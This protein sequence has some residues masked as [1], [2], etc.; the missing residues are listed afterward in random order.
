MIV[1]NPTAPRAALAAAALA[2]LLVS[3]QTA[4]AG[5]PPGPHVPPIVARSRAVAFTAAAEPVRLALALPLRSR[6]ELDLLLHRLYDPADRLYGQYLSP[7]AFTD[8]F[9][10]TEADY[11]AVADFARAQ[12]LQVVGTHPNRLLL[13]VSGPAA[14]VERAFGVRLIQYLSP[15]GRAFRA[16]SAEPR[17]PAAMKGKISA[18]VGLDTAGMRH[19]HHV[20]RPIED[21]PF[22]LL[23]GGGLN[24]HAGGSGPGG[25]MSPT[26]IKTAYNLNNL[27]LTGTGQTLA[28]FELDGYT[29]SDITAY[30]SYF[31]L[32]AVPLTRVLIDGFNGTPADGASEV[33]LDIELQIA[34]APG[35]SRIIVYM[36][37]NTSPGALDTY[38][39]I[40]T[41]N[42]AKQISTSWGLDEGSMGT[43]DMA[44]ENTIF[45]Q[46]AAQGQALYAAAGDDG[47][48]DNGASLSV[49]DPAC[50]PCVTGV[51]GT[52]LTLGAG[53]AYGSETTWYSGGYG[54]G[55]GISTYF[56]IPAWQVGAAGSGSLASTS[57]RNV[58]D[59][60]LDSD[61]AT[62]Y[63]IYFGGKWN[64]FGGT[65]CASPIWAGLHALVNERRASLARPV[66]GMANPALYTVG[67]GTKYS[68][69]FHDIADKST[70]G[71][72][73]AVAG[74]DCAT[75]WGTPNGA[76]LIA[77]LAALGGTV[78]SA[79]AGLTATGGTGTI[80]LNWTAVSGAT[81][82][83]VYR[84]TTSG[85]ETLLRAGITTATFA[86]TGLVA[87]T[88]FYYQVSASN[89]NGE[90][91]KSTEASASTSAGGSPSAPTGLTATGGTGAIT[92]K[93]NTVTGATTYSVYRGAVSTSKTL[94][95]SGLTTASFADTGL[96]G[97][98]TYYY[99]VTATNTAG[100]SAKSTE[101]SATT[102]ADT[103]L[104]A[105]TGLTA[106][107]GTGAITLKW[108]AVTGAATYNVYR[109]AT[110]ASKALYRSNLDTPTFVDS[111]LTAST[112][113]YYQV[114]AVNK[115]V[116]SAKSTEASATTA[117]GTS[118]Q[119]LLNPGFENGANATPW[120]ASNGVIDGS[121]RPAAHSGAWKAWLN[122]YGSTRT[123]TLYQQVAIPAT[124]TSATLSFWLY[125]DSAETSSAARDTLAVQ[126]RSSTGTVLATL[127]TYSNANKSSAYAQK[128]FNLAAY[129][130]K[131][132]RVYL[133]GVENSSL[134]TSFLVDDFALNV[135]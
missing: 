96:P 17:L 79:P 7:E 85:G 55:G 124:V 72:F 129:K 102:A 53:S 73:P 80:T 86:D 15:A 5:Q 69:D 88:T 126:I 115:S 120:V 114:T 125:I 65:S 20:R 66:L 90:G 56:P 117:A 132:I 47:A 118:R 123:D 106:T 13:D 22:E 113:Y 41:D 16:P 19:T 92:L 60:A 3:G 103:G 31:G 58:P 14:V 135:Q 104:S 10:P 75:G 1:L 34:M 78:P 63:A 91:A 97:S 87:S 8:R 99:Q 127:A 25:G 109:G 40:A 134:A 46:Y 64:I 27:G 76:N 45:L 38:N 21:S 84:G 32:T 23:R 48:K 101:A 74:Y 43:A 83:S 24:P 9:S 131:T 6:D 128:S 122:G 133:V 4:R 51:G 30:C 28:L 26:D 82:Y 35:A 70:N 93:W 68:S 2:A 18:V 95:R 44:A 59:V 54:G 12:G 77:D 62:G 98:T 121:R 57:K 29:A 33:T 100:E 42:L 11:S 108:T 130:G 111:G 71:Y 52:K 116:E 81:S 110:S 50:Q 36:G 112:T 61:P 39:R 89:L 94:L 67:K 105:P 107:G 37:P 49:D 119:I